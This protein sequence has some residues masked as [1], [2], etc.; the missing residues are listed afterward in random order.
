MLWLDSMNGLQGGECTRASV[1]SPDTSN[2]PKEKM[3]IVGL[4]RRPNAT[5]NAR[6]DAAG[7]YKW[8]SS[9]LPAPLGPPR[10]ELSC[11]KISEIVG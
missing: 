10:T 9:T 3:Q 1:P 4:S 11:Q 7:R 5:A 6:E 2:G 8:R